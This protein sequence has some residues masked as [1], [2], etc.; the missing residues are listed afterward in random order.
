[1]KRWINTEVISQWNEKTQRYETVS[2]EGYWYEGD[3]DLA[4]GFDDVHQS[5]NNQHE[6]TW[7]STLGSS[8]DGDHCQTHADCEEGSG[9]SMGWCTWPNNLNLLKGN[10][11]HKSSNIGYDWDFAEFGMPNQCTDERLVPGGY[12][13]SHG[14]YERYGAHGYQ[15]LL[16][17]TNGPL[18][19]YGGEWLGEDDE[20]LFD[21]YESYYRGGGTGITTGGKCH[22]HYEGNDSWNVYMC[23]GFSG[24]TGDTLK[25]AYS[26]DY[27]DMFVDI[28]IDGKGRCGL[29]DGHCQ[30][31][32]QCAP[33]LYCQSDIPLEVVAEYYPNEPVGYNLRNK[34]IPK[35]A[36]T[37]D[38]GYSD[39]ADLWSSDSW[40]RGEP[41]SNCEWQTPPIFTAYGGEE[42]GMTSRCCVC[43]DATLGIVC[44]GP[45]EAKRCRYEDCPSQ[46][47]DE[48]QVAMPWNWVYD[49]ELTTQVV[50]NGRT[51]PRHDPYDEET[52][53]GWDINNPMEWE[54]S[55][56]DFEGSD[57]LDLCLET[58]AKN[59]AEP[60]HWSL[61]DGRPDTP[62]FVLTHDEWYWKNS[63]MLYECDYDNN[64]HCTC[65]P[66]SVSSC[67]DEVR[68]AGDEGNEN[69]ECNLVFHDGIPVEG[70]GIDISPSSI[71]NYDGDNFPGEEICQL[72]NLEVLDLSNNPNLTGEIPECICDL[73]NLKFLR[74]HKNRQM[75]GQ[76]PS[77]IGNLT[78]LEHLDVA[79]SNYY[80]AIPPSICNLENLE[81]ADFSG[82]GFSIQAF[83]GTGYCNLEDGMCI[84]GINPGDECS[85]DSVCE[86]NPIFLLDEQVDT[87]G[88][89]PCE[90]GF[91]NV[92]VHPDDYFIDKSGQGCDFG[93][94]GTFPYECCDMNNTYCWSVGN[95]PDGICADGG[96]HEP[97]DAMYVNDF[98]DF[99][100]NPHPDGLGRCVD[101]LIALSSLRT[102]YGNTGTNP[103]MWTR[104]HNMKKIL[105]F[106]KQLWRNGRLVQFSLSLDQVAC[107]GAGCP[108]ITGID[109]LVE[110]ENTDKMLNLDNWI[111]NGH[112]STY[113]SQSYPSQ[114]FN[115]TIGN[116]WY[117]YHDDWAPDG[118]FMAKAL[119]VLK[120]D[121]YTF[122]NREA[123]YTDGSSVDPN[124]IGPIRM[125]GNFSQNIK[126][127]HN[128]KRLHLYGNGDG[129]A[130]PSAIDTQGLD[131]LKLLVVRDIG[132]TSIDK[133]SNSLEYVK[134]VD[135][136]YLSNI[137]QNVFNSIQYM[138]NLYYLN[139]SNNNINGEIPDDVGWDQTKLE[140]LYLNDNW[141][142]GILPGN[143]LSLV[144]SH[145]DGLDFDDD[146]NQKLQLLH[147]QNNEFQGIIDTKLCD[148]W[149]GT[150][151]GIS[152]NFN[153]NKFCDVIPWCLQHAIN[154]FGDCDYNYTCIDIAEG[155]WGG[156]PPSVDYLPYGNFIPSE[157]NMWSGD[158]TCGSYGGTNI[159]TDCQLDG[160]YWPF[161]GAWNSDNDGW[162]TPPWTQPNP[163]G[164]NSGDFNTNWSHWEYQAVINGIHYWIHSQ[165][166]PD[167]NDDTCVTAGVCF[168]EG[169]D[170]TCPGFGC[171][172]NRAINYNPEAQYDK[173]TLW[174]PSNKGINISSQFPQEGHALCNSDFQSGM[175]QVWEDGIFNSDLTYDECMG[176]FDDIALCNV[177]DDFH[178]IGPKSPIYCFEDNSDDINCDILKWFDAGGY[179]SNIGSSGIPQWSD[180]GNICY[181]QSDCSVDNNQSTTLPNGQSYN[182]LNVN[183]DDYGPFISVCNSSCIYSI[184]TSVTNSNYPLSQY[185]IE[186]VT[187]NID[188]IPI[189]DWVDLYNYYVMYGSN[190]DLDG[191]HINNQEDNHI[192]EILET[193]E[194]GLSSYTSPDGWWSSGINN[195]FNQYPFD[196]EV[197]PKTIG[198]KD[199]GM[200]DALYWM[201]NPYHY[202]GNPSPEGED[203]DPLA[204]TGIP[205]IQYPY[206]AFLW[207]SY[208][209]IQALNYDPDVKIDDGS[210]YYAVGCSN[211]DSINYYQYEFGGV[212]LANECNVTWPEFRTTCK[213]SGCFYASMTDSTWLQMNTLFK[214]RENNYSG[215][216]NPF[217]FLIENDYAPDTENGIHTPHFYIH[218]TDED[219]WKQFIADEQNSTCYDAGEWLCDNYNTAL[220]DTQIGPDHAD[221]DGSLGPFG[222]NPW[223][224][225]QDCC[226]EVIFDCT[227][228]YASNYNPAAAYDIGN[229]DYSQCVDVR[230]PCDDRFSGSNPNP[231]GNCITPVT[232]VDIMD[233]GNH[234]LCMD[235]EG[236]YNP[237]SSCAPGT[238]G[239]FCH[240]DVEMQWYWYPNDGNDLT[241]AQ[242]M[243][244][245]G[246]HNENALRLGPAYTMQP[247]GPSNEILETLCD[248][249]K[250]NGINYVTGY[251]IFQAWNH[252]L[253]RDENVIQ[254]NYLC[255]D[256]K[257]SLGD[258]V[259]ANDTDVLQSKYRILKDCTEFVQGY[260]EADAYSHDYMYSYHNIPFPYYSE[261]A[262]LFWQLSESE[263]FESGGSSG[264]T[265][266]GYGVAVDESTIH[267]V[268]YD[269]MDETSQL[270]FPG[271]I[272]DYENWD[273][274]S[275]NRNS[276]CWNTL[277]Q[278]LLDSTGVDSVDN[279]NEL[280]NI[281]EHI[282]T[283]FIELLGGGDAA[284][285][286]FYSDDF[287][288]NKSN[289]LYVWAPLSCAYHTTRTIT[290][291]LGNTCE[292]RDWY[293]I[294]NHYSWEYPW[295]TDLPDTFFPQGYFPN[296][297]SEFIDPSISDSSN[298]VIYSTKPYKDY[299][300]GCTDT[301]EK[302]DC[303][304][305]IKTNYINTGMWN[306]DGE[307]GDF[308]RS[309]KDSILNQEVCG[310]SG[311]Q[312]C[313]NHGGNPHL[314]DYYTCN[315]DQ[316]ELSV[317]CTQDVWWIHY[318]Y[319]VKTS[320]S[321]HPNTIPN[322]SNT[323]QNCL[324]DGMCAYDDCAGIPNGLN[325]IDDCGECN[326]QVQW[327]EELNVADVAN[328]ILDRCDIAPGSY[329]SNRETY[330]NNYYIN[331]SD[332]GCGC[333]EYNPEPQI[334]YIDSDGDGFG[335]PDTGTLYCPFWAHGAPWCEGD[336]V[337]CPKSNPLV[338]EDCGG[339]SRCSNVPTNS[340][341]IVP[342]SLTGDSL[343]IGV[344]S[345]PGSLA[346]SICEIEDGTWEDCLFDGESYSNP[347]TGGESCYCLNGTDIQ[348][349]CFNAVEDEYMID[350]CGICN[351]DGYAGDPPVYVQLQGNCSNPDHANYGQCNNMDCAGACF[352]TSVVDD[353]GYCTGEDT[354]QEE[355]GCVDDVASI[356][357][358][359]AWEQNEQSM[360]HCPANWAM[361]CMGV[362]EGNNTIIMGCNYC[363]D[364]TNINGNC[365][366]GVPDNVE[367]QELL[368]ENGDYENLING[369]GI[370]YTYYKKLVSSTEGA[371]LLASQAP[372]ERDD[373]GNGRCLYPPDAEES[374]V[375]G[376]FATT[377]DNY[378]FEWI[379]EQGTDNTFCPLILPAFGKSIAGGNLYGYEV[380]PGQDCAGTCYGSDLYGAYINDCGIC[381]IPDYLSDIEGYDTL[382]E[383]CLDGQNA[384]CPEY[385]YASDNIS[386]FFG[387]D[388]NGDCF[389]K[390]FI[391]D[392]GNCV[393]GDTTS[394]NGCFQNVDLYGYGVAED[395]LQEFDQYC[396][397]NWAKDCAGNCL[398]DNCNSWD[399]TRYCNVCGECVDPDGQGGN[400]LY[401]NYGSN[402][403]YIV[404]F[405]QDCAGN[406]T[407]LYDIDICDICNP[408]NSPSSCSDFNVEMGQCNVA[409][410]GGENWD[411]CYVCKSV[412]GLN[413][414]AGDG[415]FVNSG[416]TNKYSGNNNRDECITHM[417]DI[418]W[419]WNPYNPGDA[420][421]LQLNDHYFG[422]QMDC[423][424][425]C[426]NRLDQY[427]NSS[428]VING[429]ETFANYNK[430]E[431]YFNPSE[432]R[433]IEVGMQEPIYIDIREYQ[434]VL[435]SEVL[436][437]GCQFQQ[438][439]AFQSHCLELSLEIKDIDFKYGNDKFDLIL[440]LPTAC[441][442]V[443]DDDNLCNNS[444]EG[445]GAGWEEEKCSIPSSTCN[446]LGYKFT[447]EKPEA[448]YGNDFYG[449]NT[450]KYY[451]FN[452]CYSDEEIEGYNEI[453]N[454]F[455]PQCMAN[456]DLCKGCSVD[457]TTIPIPV[458][459]DVSNCNYDLGWVWGEEN[460]CFVPLDCG[461]ENIGQDG[462]IIPTFYSESYWVMGGETLNYNPT[463]FD[464]Y[465]DFNNGEEYPT[466]PNNIGITEEKTY[467][468]GFDASLITCC[469]DTIGGPN[470]N[471]YCDND[472]V[473]R[474]CD[475]GIKEGD[476]GFVEMGVIYEDTSGNQYNVEHP[477]FDNFQSQW[478]E[479]CSN[480]Y[481]FDV[482][483]CPDNPYCN[484]LDCVPVSNC[485][486]GWIPK[487]V[488]LGQDVI[489][490]T[491]SI[492]GG[493]NPTPAYNYYEGNVTDDGSCIYDLDGDG[494]PDVL[495]GLI[496]NCEFTYFEGNLYDNEAIRHGWDILPYVDNELEGLSPV[497]IIINPDDGGTLQIQNGN[498][499]NQNCG[500]TEITGEN[501]WNRMYIYR[502]IPINAFN[503]YKFEFN[504]DQSLV[505]I[506]HLDTPLY[507]FIVDTPTMNT[508]SETSNY[509]VNNECKYAYDVNQYG[510]N[511]EGTY[512]V[513][514]IL[515]HLN[516]GTLPYIHK[517]KVTETGNYIQ[518]SNTFE[519][520]SPYFYTTSTY[521]GDETTWLIVVS[522]WDEDGVPSVNTKKLENLKLVN[523]DYGVANGYITDETSIILD[524]FDCSGYYC[525]DGNCDED[526]N[527]AVLDDCGFCQGPCIEGEVPPVPQISADGTTP[528][529][530]H[531][532]PDGIYEQCYTWN[533]E[534]Y[535]YKSC[536]DCMGLKENDYDNI[537]YSDECGIC[538]IDG[539]DDGY[540]YCDRCPHVKYNIE[541]SPTPDLG[542]FNY[543][544]WGRQGCR[545]IYN[546]EQCGNTEGCI[547]LGAL[548]TEQ[549]GDLYK[550]QYI[551]SPETQDWY[552]DEDNDGLGCDF[553]C[554]ELGL[555]DNCGLEV[556]SQC[557]DPGEGW[558]TDLYTPWTLNVLLGTESNPDNCLC[559]I[560]YFDD[561]GICGGNNSN[562]GGCTDDTA[563]NYNIMSV[564]DDGSCLYYNSCWKESL[565]EG[566]MLFLENICGSCP[567]GWYFGDNEGPY[568][569]CDDEQ[570]S[571]YYFDINIMPNVDVCGDIIY[572]CSNPN[573]DNYECDNGF[574]G[575]GN[576]TLEPP[577]YLYDN[578]SCEY[579]DQQCGLIPY[580]QFTEDDSISI[581]SYPNI[582]VFD[583]WHLISDDINNQLSLTGDRLNIPFTNSKLSYLYQKIKMLHHYK[584]MM[585][586]E[587]FDSNWLN[588]SE[589]G[590][591]YF[592]IIEEY[593]FE[594][595][596]IQNFPYRTDF[597]LH[598]WLKDNSIY[599]NDGGDNYL[600]H[601][602][603]NEECNGESIQHE[604]F[605]GSPILNDI[606]QE[607]VYVI[608]VPDL[609]S[610]AS[611][612]DGAD[613]LNFFTIKEVDYA[614]DC[615]FVEGGTALD[616]SCG[617][618]YDGETGKLEGYLDV[619]CGC[620]IDGPE[621]YYLDR[622]FDIDLGGGYDGD[623]GTYWCLEYAEIFGHDNIIDPDDLSGDDLNYGINP[624][625]QQQ[626][627]IEDPK[628]YPL[629]VGSFQGQNWLS[630][631]DVDGYQSEPFTEDIPQPGTIYGCTD[632]NAQNFSFNATVNDGTCTYSDIHYDN[633]NG[634]FIVELNVNNIGDIGFNSEYENLFPIDY[635]TDTNFYFKILNINGEES[636]LEAYELLDEGN[637]IYG[638][639]LVINNTDISIGDQIQY[640]F[641]IE[642]NGIVVEDYVVRNILIESNT[643]IPTYTGVVDFFN[644]NGNF[645]TS[646]LPIL[647][648]NA[649]E[650]K[651]Y[652]KGVEELNSMQ[653][654]PY[655]V[656][657]INTVQKS[658]IGK[659]E[660]K[661]VLQDE[662]NLVDTNKFNSEWLL[663]PFWSNS[664]NTTY[665]DKSFIRNDLSFDIFEEMG[666]EVN[667]G[668][669]IQVILSDDS[670]SYYQGLYYLTTTKDGFKEDKQIII[671]TN[672]STVDDII[673]NEIVTSNKTNPDPDFG[674]RSDWIKLYNNSSSEIDI[675]GY[676]IGDRIDSVNNMTHV[677]KIPEGLGD[678]TV[679]PV[680]GTKLI[681]VDDK[682][683]KNPEMS[684][685]TTEYIDYYY[686]FISQ[687]DEGNLELMDDDGDIHYCVP[688]EDYPAF[689]TKPIII[690]EI[691]AKGDEWLELY[692][693]SSEDIDMT[694]WYLNS[695][696]SNSPDIRIIDFLICNEEQTCFDC[697]TPE[698]LN[699]VFINEI[700]TKG[701]GDDIL[702]DADFIEI[703]NNT[704]E[705]ID[706]DG[707]SLTDG[708]DSVTIGGSHSVPDGGFVVF[709]D[710]D[711]DN[712]SCDGINDAGY[713]I[714]DSTHIKI[715]W[716]IGG[717]GDLILKDNSQTTRDALAWDE[718]PCGGNESYARVYDGAPNWQCRSTA[719]TPGE[720]NADWWEGVETCFDNQFKNKD[721]ELVGCT[722][723]A[724]ESLVIYPYTKD[725]ANG[726]D[727]I[728]SCLENGVNWDD[729]GK[730]PD[731][732][733]ST[734]ESQKYMHNHVNLHRENF[735]VEATPLGCSTKEQH[736][737]G[738]WDLLILSTEPSS[739][740]EGLTKGPTFTDQITI[741]F[742]DSQYYC[743][744]ATEDENEWKCIN[745]FEND[746]TVV[747]YIQYWDVDVL[748]G[749][750]GNI[751]GNEACQDC[752]HNNTIQ[753]MSS[754]NAKEH[755]FMTSKCWQN[756]SGES[757]IG[758]RHPWCH[759]N[760]PKSWKERKDEERTPGGGYY[761][762][763]NLKCW[764]ED[765]YI[766]EDLHTGYEST[767]SWSLQ[768]TDLGF[769]GF[770][771][772]VN[773]RV[774][775]WDASDTPNLLDSKDWQELP[776][777]S[778]ISYGRCPDGHDNWFVLGS[779]DPYGLNVGCSA[780]PWDEWDGFAV[781]LDEGGGITGTDDGLTYSY[782]DWDNGNT[783]VVSIFNDIWS[784]LI[785]PNQS[786]TLNNIGDIVIN[787]IKMKGNDNNYRAFELYNRSNSDV[788][789]T[790]W[791]VID[792]DTS[793][794]PDKNLHQ[795]H[796]E[797][798]PWKL[799]HPDDDNRYQL[800][801][802]CI[803]PSGE[804][805]VVYRNYDQ[806]NFNLPKYW[807][808]GYN[809]DDHPS[810]NPPDCPCGNDCGDMDNCEDAWNIKVDEDS[811]PPEVDGIV[812]HDSNGNIVDEVYFADD[813]YNCTYGANSKDCVC[814]TLEDCGDDQ[815]H[816]NGQWPNM[817]SD[818]SFQLV[819][820]NCDNN[821][822]ENWRAMDGEVALGG[823][824][825]PVMYDENASCQHRINEY[826]DLDNFI[827]VF[828]I[829][830]LSL[831]S[832]AYTNQFYLYRESASGYGR[833][834][835]VKISPIWESLYGFNHPDINDMGDTLVDNL[836]GNCDFYTENQ[837]NN[838]EYIN[839][840]F[841]NDLD[842][843][844]N[845]FNELFKDDF[846]FDKLITRWNKL[847]KSDN[848]FDLEYID[849]LIGTKY[850]YLKQEVLYENS[851]WKSLNKETWLDDLNKIEIY[852]EYIDYIKLWLVNR[853]MWMDHNIRGI[854]SQITGTCDET[855]YQT[856][857]SEQHYMAGEMI[858]NSHCND[859]VSVNYNSESNFNDGFCEYT[860]SPFYRFILDTKYVSF[861]PIIRAE[862]EIT[863]LN[864]EKVSKKYEMNNFDLNKWSIDI[865]DIGIGDLIEYHFI[866]YTE[867]VYTL[868]TGTIE[869]DKHRTYYIYDEYSNIFEHYFND[870]IFNLENSI[871]PIIKIDTNRNECQTLEE[872]K[873]GYK[874]ECNGWYCPDPDGNGYNICD[875]DNW[876]SS[877]EL[878]VGKEQYNYH[879]TKE[880]CETYCLTAECID[881]FNI[882]DE[883]KITANMEIIYNGE[884]SVNNIDDIPQTDT[885]IGIEVRGFSH[886][887]FSKKQYSIEI[888]EDNIPAPQC[889]DKGQEWSLFCERLSPDLNI[890]HEKDCYFPNESDFVIFGPYRDKTMMKNK[891]SYDLWEEMG[892]R[893][894]RT[895]YVELI[896]N[897]SYLG[898][899]VFMEAVR[900]GKNRLDINED[901]GY[902]IKVESGAEQDFFVGLDGISKYEYYHPRRLDITDERKG[903]ISD[904]ILGL[905]R[906][907]N[908]DN[909][910]LCPGDGDYRQYID[911]DSFVD[912]HIVEDLSL[913][914]EGYSRSQ[915]WYWDDVTYDGV[916]HMGPPWDFNHS[917]GAFTPDHEEIVLSKLPAIQGQFWMDLYQNPNFFESVQTKWENYRSD[918]LDIEYT[919]GRIDGMINNFKSHNSIQREYLRWYYEGRNFDAESD[920]FKQWTLKRMA[921]LDYYWLNGGHQCELDGDIP[922]CS[923]YI[924][925]DYNNY[926]G[927][928]IYIHSPISKNIFSK[929]DTK[930]ITFNWVTS[931]NIEHYMDN[932]NKPNMVY[933]SFV[934]FSI[935]DKY[936][937][938]LIH[939]FSSNMES[940]DWNLLQYSELNEGDFYIVAN[941]GVMD[942]DDY[943]TVITS[944]SVEFSIK[945]VVREEGCTDFDAINYN[946]FAEVDDGSCKYKTDCDEKY[947]IAEATIVHEL[948]VYSGSNTISY[949]V[950]DI[951]YGD[952][953]NFFDV[954]DASYVREDG[955]TF[956]DYDS[957]IV[958]RG[959]DAGGHYSAIY[960]NGEWKVTGDYSINIDSVIKPGMGFILNLT[961]GGKI[962]W[963][964][965]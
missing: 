665:N 662:L 841:L 771:Y 608:F 511:E 502:E 247:M 120:L 638:I 89:I 657:D 911:E 362:C 836:I 894:I 138:S 752:I 846:I 556:I 226:C 848:I 593:N 202:T 66:M 845:W 60:Q 928:F 328:I 46:V 340:G 336:E 930:K 57:E 786:S 701:G 711:T 321:F 270:M 367:G 671:D 80:G 613:V 3:L 726:H 462:T 124:K 347:C 253:S 498:F 234:V 319:D 17:V 861:P 956:S 395:V 808:E 780:N 91:T 51:G 23:Y 494:Q 837:S 122:I 635:I 98:N 118:F 302:Q 623:S 833:K 689:T 488:S 617:G 396:E 161:D 345:C 111:G 217:N 774:G 263:Y 760:H 154:Q 905:E 370:A 45:L 197:T 198:C 614:Y 427:A 183:D 72:E 267:S 32:N 538:V 201:G 69:Y 616:D 727:I 578:T 26:Y 604:F 62:E 260:V 52:E 598:E 125:S 797:H 610:N 684:V 289:P 685:D 4:Q 310:D 652:K 742:N 655:I 262:G 384:S 145:A 346:V 772:H 844:F 507:M 38:E 359:E 357:W 371:S 25:P 327:T 2:S 49:K 816:P 490:C 530:G 92:W 645:E 889:D 588:S 443:F 697:V 279:L 707:W 256:N 446:G 425:T 353:C 830:E 807:T 129:N 170:P 952:G 825:N 148:N 517:I 747:D 102:G 108:N 290:T 637:G 903:I 959:D 629:F 546:V 287:Y 840:R 140:W 93:D 101:D 128:L 759:S 723:P 664:N 15:P 407:S 306:L 222:K 75:T 672:P 560:N 16:E 29:G 230:G 155:N 832:N 232:N 819:N 740:G 7:T 442:E 324:E 168:G 678:K 777:V 838:D 330:L 576:W 778:G 160:Y 451:G 27:Y 696:N 296:D 383:N 601:E 958:L 811:I 81:Y 522:D 88:E 416:L 893:G 208:K 438:I 881:G 673:L 378:G 286:L 688:D 475:G 132:V 887:G 795:P 165:N 942:G 21:P 712:G 584:Y 421:N 929:D 891:F 136:N 308:T 858:L 59:Q 492:W 314:N 282:E 510:T 590:K 348:D 876:N 809:E 820:P 37:W 171:M 843:N 703:W 631:G 515:D 599:K 853:I 839:W 123:E 553:T 196:V 1:M 467:C 280:I 303:W 564:V 618:C 369:D 654:I 909:E 453:T 579:N 315:M 733:L 213:N 581:T 487:D 937:R 239:M 264:G 882:Q 642:N 441:S 663:R 474:E 647:E 177:N 922:S 799:C 586:L 473:I 458:G 666:N 554:E 592:Y 702:D 670:G 411:D 130:S 469:Q 516:D 227:D 420:N 806:H 172:D 379:L 611:S 880:E 157:G 480:V 243:L 865:T 463:D 231:T 387:Q 609:I 706:L 561:C 405:G 606:R 941:Y 828:L 552:Y 169:Q 215:F 479:C 127:L 432:L 914:L 205:D 174:K 445:E 677:S 350:E 793:G 471:R 570:Y 322:N 229:C 176:V 541:N 191:V 334:M 388:C 877:N 244:C 824:N 464:D 465:Y 842:N 661:I 339:K 567:F 785:N 533:R 113:R 962:I 248:S 863:N 249:R 307:T 529:T 756:Q 869:Y 382:I 104:N 732:E 295:F 181:E 58:N 74:L 150:N 749:R 908:P 11:P 193:F 272:S 829:N 919:M 141:F 680:G 454:P 399:E 817:S 70:S 106:G 185:V 520:G 55:G 591:K 331:N 439:S 103:D 83:C 748:E 717:S 277:V 965:I 412:E 690:S 192:R 868:Y 8:T 312:Y 789:L 381:V 873:E 40:A 200:L 938:R 585:D 355:Q 64:I 957:V 508:I 352:G 557:G 948:D 457:S 56:E 397:Y 257:S 44:P 798:W 682:G 288:L 532:D 787:E 856:P 913:N 6:H 537:T 526:P 86:D 190:L 715:D 713:E 960:L 259:I 692:N 527:A 660:I 646:Y 949:P 902:I 720:S 602:C 137:S 831:N 633:G 729:S 18:Q 513:N 895:K 414:S 753:G 311:N 210:C 22:R 273:M 449:V 648:I 28:G 245:V 582:G 597:E 827:D 333:V 13:N 545:S 284:E 223:N 33:G 519:D 901:T 569:R 297:Y 649:S 285:N 855:N 549:Q 354:D 408:I 632:V 931:L 812:L 209:N 823:I 152:L 534:Q 115:N 815:Q 497:N 595:D 847:R 394:D 939:K 363:V 360:S 470:G 71:T 478:N 426:N 216:I 134:I 338:L 536:F 343:D 764:D 77:C 531:F 559:G 76:I 335:D 751:Y 389:G 320:L 482:S 636:S 19:D 423:N 860:F 886:R 676:S 269:G 380:W 326:C 342:Y 194:E 681:W 266:S 447:F 444:N 189:K 725:V 634:M 923:T 82:N 110:Y 910:E 704:G 195:N 332:K 261:D 500:T 784:I 85:D 309:Q 826:I 550:Y 945:P 417:D 456:D 10:I 674:M 73:T 54:P 460:S 924:E 892:N 374:G 694:G 866:K 466:I 271:L 653:D 461:C 805:L 641:Y 246:V 430:L 121:G 228:K 156:A 572:G 392:C 506:D 275:L 687:T 890:D 864:G 874:L 739:D 946:E 834:P 669:H 235:T 504:Y 207:E 274:T 542:E 607:N 159:Y 96:V 144:A 358:D 268:I 810:Y 651:L 53:K 34:L 107:S 728:P 158:D 428:I 775:L 385:W 738:N 862:L 934:K 916:V 528:I 477:Y 788:D 737:D 175:F 897:D 884:N 112:N 951:F 574:C 241:D 114:N 943:K 499:S 767:E 368:C 364:I 292:I 896:V 450:A 730:C 472:I 166:N 356:G 871:L 686:K 42:F 36:Y 214:A 622:D 252:T 39:A 495:C 167:F 801:D 621:L 90:L 852:D 906:C 410:N 87:Y 186:G 944:N 187:G 237:Y 325:I 143:L 291:F 883:P 281:D 525:Q 935:Y 203:N 940:Y 790:D 429:D 757:S 731:G 401:I 415:Q 509:D 293:L 700:A 41:K 872:Y 24:G 794:T 722:L 344:N 921:W 422:D 888:Q 750:I 206:S 535:Q 562:C 735:N 254:G 242:K 94:P 386:R 721:G 558:N 709:Y 544:C 850:D 540:K 147:L 489:G 79:E 505:G 523:Y 571:N 659:S 418:S 818:N 341:N 221:Y 276:A 61:W 643:D 162:G 769:T 577:I 491:D 377:F 710:C 650:I 105:N 620:N 468:C 814:L 35:K 459:G 164:W 452:I 765:T 822:A 766:C 851:R 770:N 927:N 372:E 99:I 904:K 119:E 139:L 424:C 12:L 885:R 184:P 434:S 724:G 761:Y 431:I 173:C 403:Q 5:W 920:Y 182:Y 265:M 658:G 762:I 849:K 349:T 126:L 351:G 781:Y 233:Y 603:E 133:L 361:D 744:G 391:D 555:D 587:I 375:E 219:A 329:A 870:F 783:E 859:D 501:I 803:L 813:G 605:I 455:F 304:D 317:P 656:G 376:S 236:K 435:L 763:N 782:A 539:I 503:I 625:Q 518:S 857:P 406:C 947:E 524:N 705:E 211:P 955:G 476:S 496:P 512:G 932:P 898:V 961:V 238:Q 43:P 50:W 835:R 580:C 626:F 754:D 298:N 481:E 393:G 573:A 258:S 879:S 718:H 30:N 926:N 436:S 565:V 779:Q 521:A 695:F 65:D 627:N 776:G 612:N 323:H 954:L 714:I 483:E 109:G 484:C 131:D 437:Y 743:Y 84:G 409:P 100:G 283:F 745:L 224:A 146:F 294:E 390:A 485:P 675:A 915:Y 402:D 551:T 900:A 398:G 615:N 135:N 912:Y 97:E 792:Q 768:T 679:I 624:N 78:N 251:E 419:D 773:D 301:Q 218:A 305:Y 716:G 821:L 514:Q 899:Y 486:D 67:L 225:C 594:N 299:R 667:S 413:W 640:Y 619:G 875:R 936:S 199:S 800:E 630:T 878:N 854:R 149:D 755:C 925:G 639:N 179:W 563:C 250:A 68:C 708:G 440:S 668:K 448:W 802:G 628:I 433:I 204:G 300:F 178:C 313:C 741:N 600:V 736:L 151:T 683:S 48:N 963:K 933:D 746:S 366:S 575:T 316:Q 796:P 153:N 543:D 734:V 20:P 255:A 116:W 918:I 95:C 14:V 63:S 31:S 404:Q 180:V 867:D 804:Y 142:S 9:H 950:D 583:G 163:D 568:Y 691:Q 699:Q 596:F 953:I 589:I 719:I 547:W 566:E 188:G 117:G 698:P 548:N 964:F 907:L 240:I 47:I 318:N 373:V 791:Y 278:F 917:F 337:E 220:W 493:V 693:R 644:Y 212:D 758:R 400:N 365:L